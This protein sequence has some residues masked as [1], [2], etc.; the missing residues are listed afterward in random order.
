[1]KIQIL[2]RLWEIEGENNENVAVNQIGPGEERGVGFEY[3]PS[4]GDAR[5]MRRKR[6]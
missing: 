3:G 6:W 4:G 5:G 2:A 1:M